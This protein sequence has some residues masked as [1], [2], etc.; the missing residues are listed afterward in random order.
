MLFEIY[1]PK[2][3][4]VFFVIDNDLVQNFVK[5]FG[6]I[7]LSIPGPVSLTLTITSFVLL[8]YL[9]SRTWVTI[10]IVPFSLVNLKALSNKLVIT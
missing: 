3:V 1:S 6:M 2:P 10:D 4:P 5:R 8:I 9:F 7:S